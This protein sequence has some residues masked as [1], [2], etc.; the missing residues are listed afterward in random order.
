MPAVNLPLDDKFRFG[1]ITSAPTTAAARANVELAERGGYDSIW[2]GGAFRDVGVRHV[3]VDATGPLE[4]REE[5]LL[6]FGTEV[7][8][9]L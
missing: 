6:R 1:F 9:L 3:I 5:Q 2:T 7:R 8:P 4:E